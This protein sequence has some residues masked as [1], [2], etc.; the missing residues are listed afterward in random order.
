MLE[1][2]VSTNRKNWASKLDEALWAYRTAFKTPIGMSPFKLV[3]GKYC[4]LPVELEHKAYW[5]LRN[6]NLD[7]TL[8]KETRLL[9]IQ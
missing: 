7:P 2:V 6:L 9:Q 3:Y 8:A 4:H 1:K 5:A